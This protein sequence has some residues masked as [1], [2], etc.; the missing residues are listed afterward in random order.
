MIRGTKNSTCRFYLPPPDAT[1][2]NAPLRFNRGRRIKQARHRNMFEQMPFPMNYDD[3]LQ[4]VQNCF[5]GH[6]VTVHDASWLANGDSQE[7]GIVAA[8]DGRAV[9][10][11]ALTAWATEQQCRNI[12]DVNE[13][14][15]G[16]V[17]Q[18]CGTTAQQR[19]YE[20]QRSLTTQPGSG[21]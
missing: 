21:S 6:A 4:F 20:N 3:A 5:P 14:Q 1:N 13:I 11:F 19:D 16:P 9:A 18:Y 2:S 15:F 17:G 7:V 10:S 8:A 12:P